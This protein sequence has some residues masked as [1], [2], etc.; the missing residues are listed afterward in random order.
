MVKVWTTHEYWGRVIYCQHGPYI[1]S[2]NRV[3]MYWGL[4]VNS[5]VIST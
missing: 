3:A 5:L 2:I 4:L 1:Y